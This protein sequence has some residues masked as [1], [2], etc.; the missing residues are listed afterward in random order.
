[1]RKALKRRE[2]EM[3]EEQKLLQITYLCIALFQIVQHPPL[4]SGQCSPSDPA[5][6]YFKY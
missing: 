5:S 2:E 3:K 1:M 6:D 4:I